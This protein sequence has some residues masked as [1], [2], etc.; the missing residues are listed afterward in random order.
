MKLLFIGDTHGE[1]DLG[2]LRSAWPALGLGRRD[3]VIHCGDFGAP[4]IHDTDA[5]LAWWQA[6]P[7]KK[8]VCLGNHENYGWIKR[9]PLRRRFGA[10]GYDLGGGIFA[11]LAGQVAHIGGRSFWFYTGGL[12]IDFFLRTPGRNAFADELL[13]HADAERALANLA[14]HAPVDYVVTHDGPRRHVEERFGFRIGLPPASYYQHFG[15]PPGSRAH[16]G[17]VLDNVLPNQY[18]K[19]YFGHHH[20]DDAYGR[21]R[22]LYRV[23]VLE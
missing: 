5:T 14:R 22:C 16:P 23:M 4:W 21:L 11:P 18:H 12:S 7:A 20:H 19:W 15:E 6:L 3:A 13:P 10:L 2:K 1:K 17:Y 8:V 9:Q